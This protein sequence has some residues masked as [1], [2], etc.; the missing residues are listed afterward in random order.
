MSFV[1][2]DIVIM[3]LLASLSP[4]TCFACDLN[5]IRGHEHDSVFMNYVSLLYECYQ[6][7]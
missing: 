3:M 5:D 2:S 1:S 7:C 6:L 4:S